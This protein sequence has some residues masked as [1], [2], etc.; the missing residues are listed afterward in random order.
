MNK[1]KIS[2]GSVLLGLLIS[3]FTIYMCLTFEP[4]EREIN[5]CY[6]VYLSGKKIGLIKSKE[7]LY[8]LIDSEQQ[9]VKDKYGVDKVHSPE[10][11]EIQ[12]IKT[13]RTNI[14]T[15]K[16]VYEKIK[17]IEPFTIEG[18][19][20]KIKAKNED[21]EDKKIY[22]LNKD[23]LDSAVKNTVLAFVKEEEYDNYL[24]GVK[25]E[26]VENGKEIT[27]IYLEK[28][29]TLRKTYIST[30]E[31]IITDL[32]TLNMYFLFGTDKLN[33]SYKVKES[34][35]LETIAYNN[36]LGVEDLLIANPDIGG[37]NALLAAGQELNVAPVKPLSNIVVES[38][39][40]QYQTIEYETKAEF[41]KNLNS[42]ESYVKQQ[43]SNGLSKVVY[44]TK[45]M[46]GVILA[47]SM[48][49]ED[50]ITKTVDKIVVYGAK[51][52]VYYGTKTYFAW[53]TS[54]PFRISSG[55]GYRNHPIRGEYHFH[56]ALDIT[57]TPKKDIYSIQD[58]VVTQV[59]QTGYNYGSGTYVTIDHGDG[60]VA[61]YL[62]LVKNSAK[63]KVGE[64]V[65]KGQIIGT[66][67]CT[68]SCSGTHLDFR[69]KKDGEYISPMSLYQ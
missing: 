18:Y 34:D 63:V 29:V 17:D 31:N 42:D 52:V 47:S 32:N 41:D 19:E 26:I 45:E 21:E 4:L 3:A 13:Y 66:M 64:K 6:Q 65:T 62:H 11:L 50:V 22:I 24:N 37:A 68:G 10:G 60:Y 7:E 38:F 16:E 43:G 46:N 20:V 15:A 25:P 35:T 53:P 40:T 14:M 55:Y 2:I 39:D 56:P 9:D 8:D 54:K 57:G 12:S 44:A 1:K 33:S 36:K 5:D 49:S 30:E 59:M 51:N 67:G 48:V 58:G 27:D 69:V 23:D 28:N 61:S